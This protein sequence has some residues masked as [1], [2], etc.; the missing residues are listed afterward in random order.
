TRIPPVLTRV[1]NVLM[2]LEHRSEAGHERGNLASQELVLGQTTLDLRVERVLLWAGDEVDEGL[3]GSL[4]LGAGVRID[5][6]RRT[7]IEDSRRLV[8]AAAVRKR[9]E[10]EPELRV[11]D[12]DG[13][14]EGRD[15]GHHQA[16][17]QTELRT[18]CLDGGPGHSG[19]EAARLVHVEVL[20][21]RLMP[22]GTRGEARCSCLLLRGEA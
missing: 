8:L 19:L 11:R 10:R 5:A 12:V 4:V 21:Q 17:P 15:A 14:L 6:Q 9:A 22:P 2:R 20:L 7:E 18:R 13:P 1:E 3:R 16:L